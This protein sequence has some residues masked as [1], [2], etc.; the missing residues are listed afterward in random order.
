MEKEN[1]GWVLKKVEEDIKG[2]VF[3]LTFNLFPFEGYIA[4]SYLD[5]TT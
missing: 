4:F 5:L 3:N 2:S 1:K